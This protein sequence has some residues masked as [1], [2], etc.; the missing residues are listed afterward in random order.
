MSGSGQGWSFRPVGVRPPARGEVGLSLVEVF[1][2]AAL[3][4]VALL[5]VA[6]AFPS[7]FRQVT[8]GGQ[9]TKATSL[10]HEMMEAIRSEP[11]YYV[12]RYNGKDGRGISTGAPA[13]FPDDWPLPCTAATWGEQFCGHTKLTRW[14]QDLQDDRT[15]GRRLANARGSVSVVDHENPVAGGGGAV[16]PATT[17]LRITV[18][19]SWD[20]MLGRR[21]VQLVST[22]PCARPGCR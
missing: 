3:L 8:D 15:D 4:G 17:M 20:Q 18:A 11:S 6:G 19:V 10:A 1:I 5:G 2:A 13:N 7:A 16:S 21:A 22:V 14:A 12:V 9:I